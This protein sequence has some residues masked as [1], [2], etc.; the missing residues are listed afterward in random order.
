MNRAIRQLALISIAIGFDASA[1][2]E[3]WAQ[4]IDYSTPPSPLVIQAAQAANL[5]YGLSE[6]QDLRLVDSGNAKIGKLTANYPDGF[7]AAVYLDNSGRYYVAFAGTDASALSLKTVTKGLETAKDLS[8]DAMFL[9]GQKSP[10][11]LGQ[12]QLQEAL[13]FAQIAKVALAP[14]GGEAGGHRRHWAFSW[15]RV[16]AVCRKYRPTNVTD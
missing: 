16:G 1:S 9:G 10:T 3:L 2:T 11:I 15:R 5:V 4:G 7:K 14:H 8:A 6:N 12:G 13:N